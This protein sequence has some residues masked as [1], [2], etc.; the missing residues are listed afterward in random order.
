MEVPCA[1]L[2]RVS[3]ATDAHYTSTVSLAGRLGQVRGEVDSQA[4]KGRDSELEEVGIE[5]YPS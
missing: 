4:I 3:W 5:N 2:S 1:V